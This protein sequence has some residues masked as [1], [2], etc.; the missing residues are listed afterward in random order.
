MKIT[1]KSILI[2]FLS[3]QISLGRKEIYSHILEKDLVNWGDRYWGVKHNPSTYSRA[4]RKLKENGNI[5]EIDVI[6]I[7]KQKDSSRNETG[8]KLITA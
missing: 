7:I 3:K 6:K 5:P 2:D 4:W 1:C 8:W